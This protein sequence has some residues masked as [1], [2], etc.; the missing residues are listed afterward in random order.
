MRGGNWHAVASLQRPN[1][2][3]RAANM[4]FLPALLA[5]QR[6]QAKG[7]EDALREEAREARTRAAAAEERARQAEARL[8]LLAADLDLACR[9]AREPLS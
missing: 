7:R 6:A 1:E 4:L 3:G 9:R 2:E 8:A 5:D